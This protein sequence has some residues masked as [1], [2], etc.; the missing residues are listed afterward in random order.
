M[1]RIL[2]GIQEWAR[3]ESLREETGTR[4]RNSYQLSSRLSGVL[5]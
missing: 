4:K 3:D 2:G 1:S 5:V